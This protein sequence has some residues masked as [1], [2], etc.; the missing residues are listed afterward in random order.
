MK[1]VTALILGIIFI[2][3]CTIAANAE[4]E[5]NDLY[6]KLPAEVKDEISKED[7][8]NE[9]LLD[10]LS[11]ENIWA[12]I[13]DKLFVNSRQALSDFVNI[14]AIIIV[15]MFASTLKSG[16]KTSNPE[17]AVNLV[18]TLVLG[19]AVYSSISAVTAKLFKAVYDIAIFQTSLMAVMG[20][21]IATGGNPTG[22]AVLPASIMVVINAI[23]QINS[24]VLLPLIKVFFT[25][26]LCGGIFPESIFSGIAEALKKFMVWVITVGGTVLV[27]LIGL[28]KSIARA[29]D[30]TL[31]GAV[32]LT[33]SSAIPVIGGVMKDAYSAVVGSMA[34]IKASAGVIGIIAVVA[35][36]LPIVITTLIYM[37]S[38]RAASSLSAM[39]GE[40]NLSSLLKSI[41]SI[42]DV[43]FAIVLTEGAFTVIAISILISI[44]GGAV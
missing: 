9:G 19:T 3:A 36:L 23:T 37:F 24:H 7:V 29:G 30:S 2:L 44:G 14:A 34:A 42:W 21:A 28:Q 5:I 10:F 39:S 18:A 12:F 35:L 27:G 31:T 32:K 20:A 40:K 22:A 13:K 11:I 17:M 16:I 41:S 25:L 26:V 6:D 38:F 1:R 43:I 33:I 8:T 15:M 4:N